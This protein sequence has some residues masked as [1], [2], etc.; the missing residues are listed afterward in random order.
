MKEYLMLFWNVSGDGSYDI[1]PQKMQQSM[2]AWQSWIGR[3]AGAGKLLSTKPINWDGTI[4]SNSGTERNP[5]ILDNKMVTGYLICKADSQQE[6]EQ[7]SQDC[8]ILSHE[9]GFV[10]V[11]EVAPFEL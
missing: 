8:P 5:A 2:H 7:W 1:D 4:I 10:E 3:I 6:V 9:H 11:R